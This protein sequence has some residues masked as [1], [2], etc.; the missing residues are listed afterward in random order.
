MAP[1]MDKRIDHKSALASVFALIP[2]TGPPRRP[3][4]PPAHCKHPSLQAARKHQTP[5]GQARPWKPPLPAHPSAY[6]GSGPKDHPRTPAQSPAHGLSDFV[7]VLSREL[8]IVKFSRTCSDD[9]L[10]NSL[11]SFSGCF[12]LDCFSD[13]FFNLFFRQ[14]FRLFL[15]ENSDEGSGAI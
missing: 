10:D 4:P 14:F 7:L 9:S 13:G 1:A 5:P 15:R 3:A 11:D 12:C 6:P 2:C 8:P